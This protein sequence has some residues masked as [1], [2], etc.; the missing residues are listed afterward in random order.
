MVPSQPVEPQPLKGASVTRVVGAAV[1]L[2]GF[3]VIVGWHAGLT[4]VVQIR[5]GYR[6]MAYGAALGFFL[7]GYA[8]VAASRARWS[9]V[10]WLA[11]S[12]LVVMLTFLVLNATAIDVIFE[13]LLPF[14][15]PDV[16]KIYFGRV[17]PNALLSFVLASG[18]L[19]CLATPNCRDA[20]IALLGSIIVAI[21]ATSVLGY[22]TN[23]TAAYSWRGLP[24]M[25]FH[26]ACGF[27]LVG[28][29]LVYVAW[30][31]A[32]SVERRVPDWL[33]VPLGI[34]IGTVSL[35]LWQALLQDNRQVLANAT[36]ITGCTIAIGLALSVYFGIAAH[37]ELRRAERTA[38]ELEVEI[39]ERRHAEAELRHHVENSPLAVIQWDARGR[40]SRWSGEAE[41]I[42]G[43]TAEEVRG[44]RYNEWRFVHED[45][46]PA[47]A[48]VVRSLRQGA[49]PHNMIA[50]RSYRRDGTVVHCEWYN[51]VYTDDRGA[52]SIFSLVLDVTERK[53]MEDALRESERRARD[54]AENLSEA[55]RRKDE[56]LATLA[57]ELRNPLAPIRFALRILE[58][59][60]GAEPSAR[61]GLDVI[62]R[63]VAQLVRLID[64]LLDVSRITRN[65]IQLRMERVELGTLMQA[66]VES[67]EPHISS[68]GHRLVVDVDDG[69][70]LEADATRL[71]Q[72]FTN[73]LNNAAKFTPQRG[74]IVLSARRADGRA[75]IRVRDTGIGIPPEAIASIF[76]MF[77]QVDSSLERSVGGLGIGLTLAKRI[78]EMHH[79]TIDVFSEGLNR[80]TEFIVRLPVAEAGARVEAPA[81]PAPAARAPVPP[82]KVLIVDDNVDS[83]DL[84]AVLVAEAGHQTRVVHDGSSALSAFADLEP[85]AVL[86]DIGLPGINGYDVAREMKVRRGPRVRLAAITGWG[87]PEDRNLARAAGFDTHFT[88]PADPTVIGSF[89]DWVAHAKT[90]PGCEQ[91]V[92][93]LTRLA[94]TGAGSG[95]Y[96]APFTRPA[97]PEE[98]A[99][100]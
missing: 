68:S 69:M 25:A 13:S 92:R 74:E 31:Q 4:R 78:V 8:L 73:L 59:G 27:I 36:L 2:L 51:S 75:E 16:L 55:D 48:A 42:F 64:D 23:L 99:R 70:V 19:W 77:H 96:G 76:E 100:D 97:A 86:L 9:T 84:L 1:A 28:S 21:G 67:A 17:P 63:Q 41:R 85:D 66:V 94:D 90:C 81:L 20:T 40:I 54:L 62:G 24:A 30:Q 80:G 3:A 47:V 57:H 37:R 45:D 18:A 89:L 12:V 60:V 49:Q 95:G 56:F 72:V 22:A 79:G 98:G 10:R 50:H 35:V 93:P 6:P 82:L 71:V 87:Q 34:A 26:G 61:Q 38:S 65:K 32:V 91:C 7:V 43:W 44:R 33:P 29:T 83:A 58:S 5:P 46:A 11:G 52:V 15:D 88:K 14:S 53:R 39:L